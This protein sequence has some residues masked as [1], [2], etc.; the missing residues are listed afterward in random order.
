[1]A[2]KEDR[3]DHAK[4]AKKNKCSAFFAVFALIFAVFV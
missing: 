2:R 3:K 4:L 1:M